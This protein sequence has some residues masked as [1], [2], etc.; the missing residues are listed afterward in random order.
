ME[1]SLMRS[2]ILVT[3]LSAGTGSAYLRLRKTHVAWNPKM[4]HAVD[5]VCHKESAPWSRN[6]HGGEGHLAIT[7]LN[8]KSPYILL[9]IARNISSPVTGTMFTR[10]VTCEQR[11]MSLVSL[12]FAIGFG[13]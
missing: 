13:R 6:R 12:I 2:F 4:F 8:L 9:V 1:S 7:A 5:L 10:Q 3:T 11:P